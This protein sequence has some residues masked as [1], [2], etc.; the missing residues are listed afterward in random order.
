MRL[1][2]RDDAFRYHIEAP[3]ECELEMEDGLLFVPDPDDPALPY[4]LF[5]DLE[6]S[7][8]RATV[9]PG[10]LAIGYSAKNSS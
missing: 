7:L 3:D 1:V 6:E 2:A 4:C 8:P 10:W 9:A 5:D